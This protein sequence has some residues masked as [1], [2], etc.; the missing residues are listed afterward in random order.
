MGRWFDAGAAICVGAAPPESTAIQVTRDWVHMEG[1]WCLWDAG[2]SVG[3]IRLPLLMRWW[4][5]VI[6]AHRLREQPIRCCKH[7]RNTTAPLHTH[8]C[9]CLLGF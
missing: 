1:R 8:E 7:A 3:S 2:I 6:Q 5:A 4:D 9:V